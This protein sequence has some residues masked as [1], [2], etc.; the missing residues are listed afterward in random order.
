MNHI[1]LLYPDIT[2]RAFGVARSSK[3]S[4]VRA[5]HLEAHPRCAACGR[6]THLEVH[7]IEPFHVKPELELEPSNL[8]TLCDYPT[9]SCHL[10]LGHLG[11]WAAWNPQVR[12]WADTY[13]E[14]KEQSRQRVHT[15]PAARP[16]MAPVNPPARVP[17]PDVALWS[18][19]SRREA[20]RVWIGAAIVLALAMLY[21]LLTH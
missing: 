19:G 15:E 10:H 21:A 11:S 12:A 1:P 7:H 17:L 20:I 5:A 13:R 9:A 16:F 2:A 4:A 6:Y 14:A 18:Y 8:L 3:W